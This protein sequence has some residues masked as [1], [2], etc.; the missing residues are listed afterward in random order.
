M[1]RRRIAIDPDRAAFSDA[2]IVENKIRS[3]RESMYR[4]RIVIDDWDFQEVYYHGPGEYEPIQSTR[5]RIKIGEDWGGENVTAFFKKTIRVPKIHHGRPLFLDI[6]VG[7]EALLTVNGSPLQ[8]LD[9]YRSLVY[10]TEKAQAG[11]SYHCEIEAFV[12]SQPFEKW[13]KDTGNIRHFEKAFLLV[14]DREIEDFYYDVATAFLACKSFSDDTEIYDFLFEEIDHALR[15]IDFYEED[16][17]RYKSQIRAAKVYLQEKIYKSDR[18]KKGGQISLVGQSHLDIVFMWPYIETIRKNIRTTSSVLNLMREFPELLFSQSQQKLYEDLKQYAP[19]LFDQVKK[20]QQEGRWECVGGMYI[21]PDCNLISGESFVRQIL[22]GKRYFRKEFGVDAKT[23]WLPDVFGMSWSIPQILLKAGMKYVSSIKLTSWN[24]YNDFPFHTF[25][26]Q[27]VDGSRVLTH[28][29]NTHFNRYL[30]P[31]VVKRHWKN[32]LQKQECGDSLMMYGMADGGSGPT[33]EMINYARRLRSFPGLPTCK[34]DKIDSYFERISNKVKNLPVWNDELYLEGHRGTYT[35]AALLKKLNRRCECLYREAE[36]FSSFA[37]LMGLP[38]PQQELERGWK[39]I[40]LHQ[41]HDTLPGSHPKP[42]FEWAVKDLEEAV[43]IG[44]KVRTVALNYLCSRIKVPGRTLVVFNSLPWRR[45]DVVRMTIDNWEDATVLRDG[46]G[47][48]VPYQVL[49]ENDARREIAFIAHDVPSIGYKCFYFAPGE[50]AATAS[51]LEVSNNRLENQFFLIE[52]DRAGNI[53]K[54]LDKR[55]NRDV[56]A[57]SQAGNVFQLFEDKPGQY[58]AWD[59]I[60]NYKDKGWKIDQLENLAIEK[61]GPVMI[62][63]RRAYSFMSSQI[64]QEIILYSDLARIDFDTYVNW[65]ETEKLLK[66]SFP[67]D[68]LSKTATYELPFANISRPTHTSTTWD[69]AKFEVCG[70]KWADLSEG[71][72]GVSIL[73]DCKYGHDIRDNVMRLTLLK[74]PVYPNPVGDKGE[75]TF[76]YSLYPHLDSWREA[77]TLLRAYE[78]NAP[79]VP[80]ATGPNE[81]GILPPSASFVE[82]DRAGVFI[83]AIKKAEDSEALVFRLVEQYQSRGPVHCR[84]MHE[85]GSISECNLLEEALETTE[86]VAGKRGFSVYLKPFEIKSLLIHFRK[87][88]R[89]NQL[90][91]E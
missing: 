31:K 69:E 48:E 49:K 20:R 50:P 76:T 8:G 71:D 21:E 63:I 60:P 62:S 23:C 79:L 1:P 18:F 28:F 54:L 38:Y 36:I 64:N 77:E 5:K 84:F 35:S 14:I 4:D 42:A 40:L 25:W 43:E 58:S 44:T 22:Y 7:G 87:I 66:V 9:Y 11:T 61:S 34:I 74:A 15:L 65:Q 29:P 10:L 32:Y 17:E 86:G 56:L 33:R 75:H 52:L 67:V 30:E 70:H 85:I 6:R 72:Y 16:F 55:V 57:P 13:F 51:S 80:V 83:E 82:L 45:T 26:W 3:L 53:S 68:I 47:N 81:H 46:T 73:N 24:D 78:V 41:F 12:R 2:D 88:S 59:I 39:K 89:G 37:S 91:D 19:E 27:G 90:R